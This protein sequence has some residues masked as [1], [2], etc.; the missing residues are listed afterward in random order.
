MNNKPYQN[1]WRQ[2]SY[3]F[4]LSVV[5][6][7]FTTRPLNSP[8]H[9]FIA[10]DGLGYYSY[11]PAK[12]IYHDEKLDWKWFNKAHNAN[13]QYSTF[14]N[15]EDNLLV[16][17][18][19]K[20]INKYYQGLSYI[21]MPFFF[22]G[23]LAAKLSG[24]AAD[25]YSL[26][27]QLAMGVASLFYLLLG[28]FF[29]RKL[30]IK[31]TGDQFAGFLIPASIF[32]GTWLFTYALSANTLSH[33]YSFTFITLFVY[34]S[35]NFLSE[36]KFRTRQFFLAAFTF[37]I[38]ICIRPLTGLILLLVPAF[39]PP[40]FFKQKYGRPVITWKEV[41]IIILSLGALYHTLHTTYVQTGSWFAYTYTD[42]KFNFGQAR[43]FDALFSYHL[44]LF[45]YVPLILLS[46]YG[47]WFMPRIQ[48]I[49]LS[50]FFFGIIFLY[51]AWW[52]WPIVKRAL[53]DFYVIPA[54]MLSALVAGYRKRR[55]LIVCA[56]MLCVLYFQF[57]AM[58]LRR[59]ILDENA[60]YSEI[61]WRNFFRTEKANQYP[62]PPNT[63]LQKEEFME[64]FEEGYTGPSTTEKKFNGNSSL[65]LDSVNY[66]N[67]VHDLSY[68]L[69][70]EKQGFR[71]IR[72]SM[73][74][75]FSEG[76][77]ST[78]I[79][80]QFF[81]T[82]NEMVREVPFYLNEEDIHAGKW[83]FKE[84]GHEIADVDSLTINTV[85]HIGFTIWNVE[86]R[87]KIYIDDAKVE[88][89]LTDR[90]FETIK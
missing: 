64:T 67:R 72:F 45:V 89:I 60:T 47:I 53:V 56:I 88:F 33:S 46:L 44:G 69:F 25:G 57:K 18:G 35:N 26:P 23:H 58:Q 52:Y 21:W 1:T 3:L 5:L 78:H 63:I 80:M 11:L 9:P 54:V 2:A 82:K 85:S 32:Y 4:L 76:I 49:I 65:L 73:Q 31:L 75:Y 51:S 38:C 27:Y 37:I 79:F 17:Y 41:L 10:G 20:R 50:L 28:L 34:F 24:Y 86:A 83:D 55:K 7:F 40:G 13:Y 59:G 61:F 29:L 66:I 71:K 15:P 48:R 81:N 19:D 39:I 87:R 70:F 74:C 90:S 36:N 84:F 77:K 22:A 14:E 43:F 12:F 68:P 62:I 42:E 16:K 8:W 30:I 6:V